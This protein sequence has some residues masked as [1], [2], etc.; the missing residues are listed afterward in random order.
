MIENGFLK[1]FRR[2]LAEEQMCMGEI[3]REK[4]RKEKRGR[5]EGQREKYQGRKEEREG[6]KKKRKEEKRKEGIERNFYLES[7]KNRR[8]K[9]NLLF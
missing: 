2:L 3:M 1:K 7:K 6:G 8:K 4:E 9:R 5:G